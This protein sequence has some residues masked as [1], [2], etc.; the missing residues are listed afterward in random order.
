MTKIKICGITN[1]EDAI[2]AAECGVDAIGFNFYRNSQRYISPTA[3]AVIVE[4]VTMRVEKIGV[5][6]NSTVEEIVEI[7]DA[8]QLDMVQLHGDESPEFIE[9]LRSESDA[10]II[11]AIRI[12]PDFDPD[13]V[14]SYKADAILLDAYSEG[15]RGGTGLTVDWTIARQVAELVDQVYLAGGLTPEN[16]ASAISAVRPFAVDVAS[17]VESSAGQKTTAKVAAFI[18]AVRN[19]AVS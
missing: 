1:L 19:T 2:F 18:A 17:G 15:G 9:Q 14:L 8:V 5:F 7:E 10:T 12:G 3:A 6:V 13:D 4:K 11:K 16:V